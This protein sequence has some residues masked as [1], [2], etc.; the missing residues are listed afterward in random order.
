VDGLVDDRRVSRV[1]S[2]QLLPRRVE[3]RHAKPLLDAIRADAADGPAI[4]HRV[5]FDDRLHDGRYRGG[6]VE[7]CANARTTGQ[8]ERQDH[9]GDREGRHTTHHDPNGTTTSRWPSSG[10]A[11]KLQE[12]PARRLGALGAFEGLGLLE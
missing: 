5:T 10:H 6:W 7:E 12:D 1:A 4:D 9:E 8:S 2:I 3:D 11:T